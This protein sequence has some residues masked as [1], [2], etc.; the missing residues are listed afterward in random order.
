MIADARL[1]QA[2]VPVDD[3]DGDAAQADATARPAG[4]SAGFDTERRAVRGADQQVV[5]DQELAGSPVQTPP[6]MGTLIVKRRDTPGLPC[7]DEIEAASTGFHVRADRTA[8]GH[9]LDAA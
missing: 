4:A 6:G 9:C 8:F 1:R 2:H 3:F 7:D 5:F